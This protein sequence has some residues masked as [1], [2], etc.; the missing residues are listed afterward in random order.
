MLFL[1]QN[2]FRAF[3]H[4]S[5]TI[6]IIQ[7]QDSLFFSSYTV[8]NST[9]TYCILFLS[10]NG[11]RAFYHLSNTISIIQVQ[12]SLFFSSNTVVNSTDTYCI[13][14]LRASCLS[15]VTVTNSYSPATL[16]VLYSYTVSMARCTLYCLYCL[17][18]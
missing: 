1:S 8:V 10:H 3:Y 2:E 9:G 5:N 16:P 18:R 13:L 12:D 4:L 17:A 6:S 14:F 7:V 11:F 15:R